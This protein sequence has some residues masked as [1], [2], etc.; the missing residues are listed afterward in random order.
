ML[1]NVTNFITIEDKNSQLIITI[2]KKRQDP[3]VV[4]DMK[5]ILKGEEDTFPKENL[6]PRSL[7][8]KTVDVDD[9]GLCQQGVGACDARPGRGCREAVLV[10]CSEG[11]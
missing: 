6:P 11:L 5:C 8:C 10:H 2:S 9:L 1:P 3:R 7:L 4:A